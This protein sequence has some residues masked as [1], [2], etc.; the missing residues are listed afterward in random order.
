MKQDNFWI[1]NKKFTCLVTV[2]KQGTIT[3]TAP[4]LRNFV[5]QQFEQLTKWATLRF[6][7]ISVRYIDE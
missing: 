3:K 1:S 7:T 2:N 4:I 6:G 5:G